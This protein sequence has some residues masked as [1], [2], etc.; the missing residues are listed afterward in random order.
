MAKL[1]HGSRTSRP[2]ALAEATK[3]LSQTATVGIV[4]DG[5]GACEGSAGLLLMIAAQL[6]RA[7]FFEKHRT[8][9]WCI[10][11]HTSH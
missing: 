9:H 3:D 6:A 2:A 8:T 11:T 7:L 1:Q 4:V 10:A 5:H